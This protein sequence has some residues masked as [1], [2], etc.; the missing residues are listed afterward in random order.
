MR[1]TIDK[2]G[3]IGCG[4]C[5]SIC[6]DVFKINDEGKAEVTSSHIDI[7]HETDCQSAAGDCPVNVIKIK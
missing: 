2:D 6:P 1:V 4:L 3:C 5:E 7:K